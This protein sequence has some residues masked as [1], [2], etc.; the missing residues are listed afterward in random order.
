[1]LPE[2]TPNRAQEGTIARRRNTPVPGFEV[3]GVVRQ[4][5]AGAALALAVLRTVERREGL[6]QAVNTGISPSFDLRANEE[7]SEGRLDLL[8]SGQVIELRR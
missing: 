5:A 7:H 2:N 6:V 1:M 3:I 8:G 4:D